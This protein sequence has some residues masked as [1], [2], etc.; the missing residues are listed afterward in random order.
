MD[1]ENIP[2]DEILAAVVVGASVIELWPTVSGIV[3]V[4]SG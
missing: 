1:G 2:D 4:W 3:V